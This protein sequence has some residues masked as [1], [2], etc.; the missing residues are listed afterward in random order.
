MNTEIL[1]K[2]IFISYLFAKFPLHCLNPLYVLK[3]TK[4][5]SSFCKVNKVYVFRKEKN[6]GNRAEKQRYIYDNINVLRV[7]RLHCRP[8]PVTLPRT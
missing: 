4:C 1:S 6:G 8:N 7:A 2:Y 5:L 3:C